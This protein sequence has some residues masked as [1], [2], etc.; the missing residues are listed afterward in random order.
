MKQYLTLQNVVVFLLLISQGYLMWKIN[1]RPETDS[2][3]LQATQKIADGM[4][5]VVSQNLRLIEH[6]DAAIAKQVD[7]LKI[8]ER[9]KTIVNNHY[10]KDLSYIFGADRST[11]FSLYKKHSAEFD[12]L[13]AA[14]FFIQRYRK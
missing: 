14:G 2:R 1:E 11:Q 5:S 12:S 4:D 13:F 6:Y 9:Q 3:V 7:T 10:E 8:Y